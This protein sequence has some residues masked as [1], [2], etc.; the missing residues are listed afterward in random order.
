MV[1]DS[2]WSLE[3]TIFRGGAVQKVSLYNIDPSEHYRKEY[4]AALFALVCQVQGARAKA[5][6][7]RDH[8]TKIDPDGT[9]RK[10][11]WCAEK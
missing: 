2:S 8:M 6:I 1:L 5:G 3:M 9:S 10:L 11:D 4:P 7:G